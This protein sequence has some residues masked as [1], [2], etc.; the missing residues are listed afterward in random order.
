M[1]V[2]VASMFKAHKSTAF[3][4]LQDAF[5]L[6]KARSESYQ[7]GSK[8]IAVQD[9]NDPGNLIYTKA[10]SSRTIQEHSAPGSA[11]HQIALGTARSASFG[12]HRQ[13]ACCI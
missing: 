9:P 12:S 6:A 13:R 7:L 5:A 3:K 11:A 10:V 2:D 1:P 8:V 4:K